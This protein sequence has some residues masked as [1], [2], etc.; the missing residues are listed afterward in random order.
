[1]GKKDRK[2][3]EL[4]NKITEIQSTH[5][6]CSNCG[7]TW[8]DDGVNSGCYCKRVKE[9]ENLW[10]GFIVDGLCGLCGNTGRIGQAAFPVESIVHLHEVPCIC[11]NG[12]ALV[13]KTT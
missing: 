3:V 10:L 8:L 4:Q 1:M 2:I 12:R 13:S 9:L 6:H 5:I 7:G 11:P